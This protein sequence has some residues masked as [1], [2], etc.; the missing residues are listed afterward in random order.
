MASDSD[1]TPVKPVIVTD[2][3]ANDSDDPAIWIHPD[4]PLQ[5]LILGTDKGN[6]QNIGAIYVFDLQGNIIADKTIP[7]IQRPNNVD[8]EYGFV[9]DDDTFDIAVFTER[10]AEAI[11]VVKVPEMELIDGGGIKVFSG[12]SGP[13]YINP[14]G[15]ALYK[16]P[17]TGEIYA[18]VGRKNGPPDNYLWQYALNAEDGVVTGEKVRS[19]GQFS[20]QNEIEA[21]AV[22]DALGYVYYSDEGFGVRKYYAHPDSSNQELALFG[23][24][25]F[26]EDHEGISIY[27]ENEQ[28][29]YILVSDQ[30]DNSFRIFS[31][32]GTAEN[33]HQ[34]QF[35]KEIKLSTVESDG[36]DVTSVPIGDQFPKGLFVAMSDDGTFHYY[37]WQDIIEE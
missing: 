23:T 36:S 35:I 14:M 19:F 11:R 13:E 21:I 29:G 27:Y 33:P 7:D 12:E 18:M 25:G 10:Y 17:E 16:N 9:M 8:V 37:Q 4:D 24:E 30:Q 1:I 3:V 2:T 20:G 6:E 34:H 32:T 22:D 5:S 15:V 28:E 26:Q 31:R